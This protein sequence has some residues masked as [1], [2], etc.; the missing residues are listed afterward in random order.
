MRYIQK[1][2]G[3]LPL[4]FTNW[5]TSNKKKIEDD[6]ADKNVKGT[7]L[8]AFFRDDGNAAYDALKN[9]L[10]KEQGYICCYCGQRIENDNHTA[11]EHLQPKSSYKIKIFDY[12]NLIA[13]C[14]GGSSDK[15]HLVQKGETLL[16]IAEKYGVDVEHIME[17]YV[18][19]DEMKM[20]RKKH[21]L[22]NLAVNDRIVIIPSVDKKSQHCD[23]NKGKEV[24][25]IHPLQ[26]SC[27]DHFNYNSSDGKIISTDKNKK[28]LCDL[29]LNNNR[30]INQLRKKTIDS[31]FLIKKYLI[32]DFGHSKQLFKENQQ[33]IIKNLDN[34][35]HT[36]NSKLEPFV[37]V[38]IW[39][40]QN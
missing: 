20:F 16:S 25:D 4:A 12:N 23:I 6:I 14:R 17:V 30:Y 27:A 39:S 36:S 10:V 18:Y 8:W 11:I 38:K 22:E 24:I 7:E 2:K 19:T 26:K 28:T 37:F 31:A 15:I 35:N 34:E 5:L 1:T 29:G 9:H 21:D 13:S 33:Q 3:D 40:L 32:A